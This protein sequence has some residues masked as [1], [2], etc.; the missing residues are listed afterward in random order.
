VPA[1]IAS[2]GVRPQTFAE[3]AEMYPAIPRNIACPND[4]SPPKPMSRLKAHAKSPK[5][6]A[7]IRNTG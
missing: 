5:H 2:S 7:F 4:S 6:N 3:C 1:R